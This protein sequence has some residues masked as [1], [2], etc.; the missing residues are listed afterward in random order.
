MIGADISA[1]VRFPDLVASDA[2]FVYHQL[3]DGVGTPNRAAVADCNG[4]RA[5]G[6]SDI[7]GY[8]YLHARHGR[9]QDADEQVKEYLDLAANCGVTLP[10]WLDVESGEGNSLATHDEVKA[11]VLSALDA[12]GR[13]APDDRVWI[14][15]SPGEALSLGVTLIDEL[16]AYPLVVAAYVVPV[17]QDAPE[18]TKLPTI[19]A[20]WTVNDVVMWQY[21][22]NVP[23]YGG[24]IDRVRCMLT[25]DQL[26]AR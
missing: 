25:V 1:P 8:L 22:G 9:A 24:T 7:G 5:A 11:A 6:L 12:F 20:P 13:Y 26:K 17:G 18:P 23:A 3:T 14:Y 10:H 4:L 21:V 19:P 2:Q 16:K 15:T